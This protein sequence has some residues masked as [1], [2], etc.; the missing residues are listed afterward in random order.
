M[1]LGSF[2][3]CQEIPLHLL[4]TFNRI[5]K[6]I[7]PVGS[8]NVTRVGTFERSSSQMLLGIYHLL[9]NQSKPCELQISGTMFNISVPGCCSTKYHPNLLLEALSNTD[10]T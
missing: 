6:C 8:I 5:N 1:T 4:H 9:N 2:S 7:P 10:L 3:H